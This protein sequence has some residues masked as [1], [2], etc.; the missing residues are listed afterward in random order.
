MSE[1]ILVLEPRVSDEV[2]GCFGFLARGTHVLWFGLGG[3]DKA[4][5]KARLAE[6][7]AVARATEFA[8]SLPPANGA[9]YKPED[10]LSDIEARIIALEPH[11]ILLPRPSFDGETLAVFEAGFS[12]CRLGTRLP[13]VRRV[14]IYDRADVGLWPRDDF[15]PT[16]FRPVDLEAKLSVWR[17][18]ASLQQE[19]PYEEALEVSAR[20]HG[21]RAG[22]SFAEGYQ[23][24][25]WVAVT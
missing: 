18:Y 2:L 20:M 16:Y 11:T 1:R 8:Y 3:R 25:R 14:L 12:A 9:R 21:Q 7:R 24:L 15:Q 5:R 17:L 4:T 22:V 23:L 13:L 19:R 6:A 10:M